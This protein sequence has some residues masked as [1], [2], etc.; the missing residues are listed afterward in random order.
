MTVSD[1][2][3]VIIPTV[4]RAQLRTAVAS[5]FDQLEPGDM[6]WTIHDGVGMFAQAHEVSQ[7]SD[8]QA[9]VRVSVRERLGRWGLPQRNVALAELAAERF[10]GY[11]WTI[12]DDDAATPAAVAHIRAAIR[13]R[14]GRAFCF[15]WRTYRD[16]W[17][18]RPYNPATML[19]GPGQLD[20]GCL[21]AP[22]GCAARFGLTYEG[23]YDFALALDAEV[24]LEYVPFPVVTLRPHLAPAQR[25]A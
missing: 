1:R 24:G 9:D 8:G 2:V 6:L 5:V 10:P 18:T 17:H 22:V 16:G 4:N 13:E 19:Y 11:A 25:V 14:P 7:R 15:Q 23:D 20:A 3:C 21:V 12:G